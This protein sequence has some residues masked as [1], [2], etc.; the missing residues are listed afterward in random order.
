MFFCFLS[1]Y[2]FSAFRIVVTL[3]LRC[4]L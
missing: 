4:G 1:L 2:M 3:R